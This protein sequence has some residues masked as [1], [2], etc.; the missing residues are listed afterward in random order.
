M[1]TTKAEF[2]IDNQLSYTDVN[3]SGHYHYGGAH[4]LWNTTALADGPHTA[5]IV[6]YDTAGQTGFIQVNVTIN[7]GGTPLSPE[8]C[9]V[10]SDG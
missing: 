10:R 4:N 7:N 5:K 6:V 2:Y 9:A 1:G 8:N 3:S